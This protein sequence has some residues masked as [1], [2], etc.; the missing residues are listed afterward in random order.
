M[1]VLMIC[2]LHLTINRRFTDDEVRLDVIMEYI[3]LSYS[4]TEADL[5]VHYHAKEIK[6]FTKTPFIIS[7][8]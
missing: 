8:L 4:Q 2:N 6:Y 5:W 1:H 3:K 7:L